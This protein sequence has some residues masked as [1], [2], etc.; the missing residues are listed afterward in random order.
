MQTHPVCEAIRNKQRLRI[1]YDPG[2]RIIEPHAFG[3]STAG[4]DVIRAFQVEGAS[5]SRE[6]V[7]WKLLRLDRITGLTLLPDVF[8]GPRPEYRRGDRHMVEIYCEL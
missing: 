2:E 5:A 3:Q 1:H 4:N 7:N 6:H 8:P